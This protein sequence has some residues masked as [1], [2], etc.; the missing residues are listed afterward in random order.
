MW[1]WRPHFV[2]NFFQVEN[3][4]FVALKYIR[5]VV[6][7]KESRLKSKPM[8]FGKN[9]FAGGFFTIFQRVANFSP[10]A[11][12]SFLCWL[13]LLLEIDVPS[14]KHRR[15]LYEFRLLANSTRDGPALHAPSFCTKLYPP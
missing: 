9:V 6:G 14:I 1:R 12:Y 4:L 2:L 10:I 5:K 11:S 15:I 3:I 8:W 7:I 13:N